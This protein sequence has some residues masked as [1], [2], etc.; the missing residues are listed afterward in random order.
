[1]DAASSLQT[2]ASPLFPPGVAQVFRIEFATRVATTADQPMTSFA[3]DGTL[4][5]IGLHGSPEVVVRGELAGTLST[6]AGQPGTGSAGVTDDT[7]LTAAARQP[8]VL[9]FGADGS[10]QGARGAPGMPALVGRMWSALGEYLQVRRAGANRTWQVR[11]ADAS[12]AYV[13]RYEQRGDRLA[14][15]KLRYELVTAKMLT[16]YDVVSSAAEFEIDGDGGLISLSLRETTRANLGAGPFPGFEATTSLALR[17]TRADDARGSLVTAIEARS[18]TVALRQAAHED[19]PGVRDR[20]RIGGLDVAE[21]L[22]RLRLFERPSLDHDDQLRASRA[23]VALTALLR[24]DPS[25]LVAV[26]ANLATGGPL[27]NSLLA[28]LRDAS[29]PETQSLLA[30]MTRSGAP[31][32]PEQRLEAARSLSRVPTPTADTV[33]ALASLRSDPDVGTQ[34][35]YGLGSALHR[36]M[37]QDPTLADEAREALV[38]QLADASAPGAQAAVLTALGNAGDPATLDAIRPYL[39]SDAASVRAAA[40]QAVRRIAG[41]EVDQILAALCMDRSPDVRFSAVDAIGERES[42]AMLADAL[43]R[44]VIIESQYQVRARAVNI[45]AQWLPDLPALAKV[46]DAVASRDPNADLRRV[47]SHALGR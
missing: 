29:T 31:L 42:S 24:Q 15:S 36:L 38:H 21:A 16:S 33:A 37:T 6:Q 43:S 5:L 2:R 1:V 14:K 10:F 39:A 34:A 11:E 8:F 18:H 20:A 7:S 46:L 22:S 4:T 28:A 19:D 35:T 40:A 9:Q 32:D 30:E 44:L 47:A 3:V 41:A 45:L 13:A 23:F 17:R 27:T 25:A 26:R 12:G